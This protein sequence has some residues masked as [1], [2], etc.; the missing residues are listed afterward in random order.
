MHVI[1]IPSGLNNKGKSTIDSDM[2]D[3]IEKKNQ[4]ERDKQ[5]E[6]RKQSYAIGIS[7]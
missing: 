3:P 1:S 7:L 6:K 4:A 2:F 5:A